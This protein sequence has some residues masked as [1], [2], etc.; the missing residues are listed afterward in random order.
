M[1]QQQTE[2]SRSIRDYE[3]ESH[4]SRK[5]KAA[6]KS[7]HAKNQKQII[8]MIDTEDEDDLGQYARYIK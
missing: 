5:K 4:I 7:Q 1:K 3:N 6:A 2:T 8:E